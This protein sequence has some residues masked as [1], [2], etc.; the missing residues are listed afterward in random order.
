MPAAFHEWRSDAAGKADEA[1]ADGDWLVLVPRNR[2][3]LVMTDAELRL[4]A[5]A[6]I[7]G[8]SSQPVTG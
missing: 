8:D 1:E 5:S 3:A 7:M 6:A 2:R 4:M